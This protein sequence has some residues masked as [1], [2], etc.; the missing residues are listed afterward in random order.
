MLSK[1]AALT[2]LASL[3]GPPTACHRYSTQGVPEPIEGVRFRA[4]SVLSPARDTLTV[5]VLAKNF[6]RERRS[7]DGPAGC[8]EGISVRA[9]LSDESARDATWASV[10]WLEY[11]ASP[12]KRQAA[13]TCV[14]S[15]LV[16]MINPGST[17][18]VAGLRV[19]VRTI[20]GDSLPSGRYRVFARLQGNGRRAGVLDAGRIDLK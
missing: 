10:G 9:S 4:F 1:W 20:L 5:Q 2:I 17:G 12:P 18:I 6:S 7:I 3:V 11:E 13:R 14:S 19:P 16:A 15:K 8:D